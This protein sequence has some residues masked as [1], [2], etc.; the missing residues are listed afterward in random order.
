[1]T[2]TGRAVSRHRGASSWGCSHPGP[3]RPLDLAVVNPLSACTTP[4]RTPRAVLRPPV[5]SWTPTE[6]RVDTERLHGAFGF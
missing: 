3:C 5:L 6:D 2:G 1:M 4:C